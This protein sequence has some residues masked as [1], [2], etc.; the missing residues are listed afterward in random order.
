MPEM[1]DAQLEESIKAIGEKV[2]DRSK[3][4]MRCMMESVAKMTMK[5]DITEIH[6][7]VSSPELNTKDFSYVLPEDAVRMGSLGEMISSAMKN[8]PPSQCRVPQSPLPPTSIDIPIPAPDLEA[9]HNRHL[10]PTLNSELP[11]ALVEAQKNALRA[12]CQNNL[13]QCGLILKMYANEA[14]D[15][16]FPPLSPLP[17]NLMWLKENV[18]PEYLADPTILVCPAEKEKW[19]QTGEMTAA[20]QKAVFCFNNSAYWYPGYA[21][22][23]EKT[24]LAFTQ[25]YRKQVENGGDFTADLKD[26]DGNPIHRLREGVERHFITDINNPAGTAMIQSKL[27]VFIEK[28]GHH[29]NTINVLFMDGHVERLTCPGEFPASPSFIEALAMLDALKKQ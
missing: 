19:Q 29:D 4:D 11:P 3:E 16:L 14:P 23:D 1:T 9:V 10:T 22:P 12:S 26:T 8:A 21:L 28:P 27:P 20:E 24:G 6:A 18:Y 7:A 15:Q 5:G 17:G 25:A 2:T 13:K